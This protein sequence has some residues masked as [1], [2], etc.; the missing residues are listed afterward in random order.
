MPS[1][2][3]AVWARLPFTSESGLLSISGGGEIAILVSEP[4][5]WSLAAFD[6]SS[7]DPI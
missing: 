2:G 5:K 3:E 6:S 7:S 4:T 1:N